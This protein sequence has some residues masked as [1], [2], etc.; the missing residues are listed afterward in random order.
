MGIKS[1]LHVLLKFFEARSQCF[2]EAVWVVIIHY[3]ADCFFESL[4]N[5]LVEQ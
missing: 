5:E 3:L 2:L 1:L 4:F